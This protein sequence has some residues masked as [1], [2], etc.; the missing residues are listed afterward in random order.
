MTKAFAATTSQAE[1]AEHVVHGPNKA[2]LYSSINFV[3]LVVVLFLV[4]R[5]PAKEFFRNRAQKLRGK[6]DEAHKTHEETRRGLEIIE[7]RLKRVDHEKRELIKDFKSEAESEKTRMIAEAHEYALKMEEDAKR[8]ANYELKKARQ[9]IK[10]EAVRLCDEIIQKKMRTEV[11]D[12][13]LERVNSYFVTE[14]K[15]VGLK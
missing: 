5:K 7:A 8:I 13:D 9:M 4:A 15:K 1:H 11:T 6:L 14:V 3:I 2:L 10:E 12:A